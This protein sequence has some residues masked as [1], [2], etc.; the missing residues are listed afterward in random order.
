MLLRANPEELRRFKTDIENKEKA[1]FVEAVMADV[2]ECLE[3]VKFSELREEGMACNLET[4][5]AWSNKVKAV[6]FF[7]C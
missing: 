1:L 5:D 6:A 4:I 7:C 2:K 3:E